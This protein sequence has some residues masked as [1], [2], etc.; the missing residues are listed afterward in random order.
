MTIEH[1]DNNNPS[2]ESS[3]VENRFQR[4]SRRAKTK[5][6]SRF[7]KSESRACR[8][9][10]NIKHISSNFRPNLQSKVPKISKLPLDPKIHNLKCY[11]KELQES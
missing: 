11:I 2:F 9:E 8:R 6:K 1:V 7:T 10:V 3:L 4:E 5:F